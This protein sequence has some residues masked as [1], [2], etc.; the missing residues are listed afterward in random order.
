[1]RDGLVHRVLKW[2]PEPGV[3]NAQKIKSA[4]LT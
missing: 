4:I 2:Y 3:L 1:M